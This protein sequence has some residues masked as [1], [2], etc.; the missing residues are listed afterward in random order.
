MLLGASRLRLDEFADLSPRCRPRCGLVYLRATW[1]L[2]TERSVQASCTP[3]LRGHGRARETHGR[4]AVPALDERGFW[5]ALGCSCWH[6][7]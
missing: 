5:G 7:T 3:F 2:S 4:S 6:L 1:R